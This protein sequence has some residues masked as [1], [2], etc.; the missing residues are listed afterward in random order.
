MNQNAQTTV[1]ELRD[2]TAWVDTNV[3]LSKINFELNEGEVH[4]V[5]GLSTHNLMDFL[6]LLDGNLHTYAGKALFRGK[7]LRFGGTRRKVEVVGRKIDVYPELSVVENIFLQKTDRLRLSKRQEEKRCRE[8]L[9]RFSVTLDLHAPVKQ[10]NREDRKLLNILRAYV[11]DRPVV[12]FYEP[13]NDLETRAQECL[14]SVIEA[15]KLQ[16]RSVIYVTSRLEEALRVSDRLSVLD[17]GTFKITEQTR[18]VV[19]DPK[20]IMYMLSGWSQFRDEKGNNLDMLNAIV[21]ARDILSSSSE[22]KKELL[23]LAED[24]AKVLYAQCCIIYLVD[25]QTRSLVDIYAG[26]TVTELDDPKK[27]SMIASLIERRRVTVA[28]PD[29]QEFELFFE[30]HDDLQTIIYVPV[31]GGEQVSGLIQVSFATKRQL[32]GVDQM[33]LNTFSKE[34]AIAIETSKLIGRSML[35]QESHHRIKNNL[36]MIISLIYMQKLAVRDEQVDVND[37]FDAIIRR[38]SSIAT[39]HNLLA[40]DKH[41][42]NI[43]NLVAIIKEITRLYEI[44][45]VRIQMDVEDISIPYNKATSISLVVNE[46]VNN[47]IKH[48]F[49]GR[50]NNVIRITGRNDGQYIRLTIADNGCGFRGEL[51][52]DKLSSIGTSVIT[53]I[54]SSMK[55]TVTFSSDNGAVVQIMI[56]VSR[57]YD[58]TNSAD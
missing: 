32:S 5:V 58:A 45:N 51:N 24:I 23:Y 18:N 29:M 8:L 40:N 39:V 13:M 36:Q 41:G 46:V 42:G 10:M 48:A 12:V 19:S 22:L 11:N 14:M 4:A 25:Q 56:P 9:D 21:N 2:I 38:V 15:I 37:A 26:A 6:A 3:G 57:V 17:K 43:I 33:Y 34:I 7:P 27:A 53:S 16:G 28:T 20:E 30:G 35:L 54:V 50:T 31:D 52:P 1:L 44:N 49:K 55:G 47:C